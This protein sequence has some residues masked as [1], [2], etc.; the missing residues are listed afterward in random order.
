MVP[1]IPW[2]LFLK[3]N[4]EDEESLFTLG[5]IL[6]LKLKHWLIIALI[7]IIL[8]TH[9]FIVIRKS[10]LSNKYFDWAWKAINSRNTELCDSID[11][12]DYVT[13]KR[14]FFLE[15]WKLPEIQ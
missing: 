1:I 10:T 14:I 15:N 8:W 3:Q 13:T 11:Y 7:T 6:D 4:K 12:E 9:A 5:G 2:W